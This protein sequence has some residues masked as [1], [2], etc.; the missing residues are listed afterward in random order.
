MFDGQSYFSME[1]IPTGLRQ[2]IYQVSWVRNKGVLKQ[3]NKQNATEMGVYQRSQ[4]KQEVKKEPKLEK[5]WARK[6]N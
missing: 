6:K 1:Q 5:I 4:Q 3:T 2:K